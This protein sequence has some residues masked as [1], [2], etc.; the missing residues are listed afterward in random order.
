[1]IRASTLRHL[2][3]WIFLLLGASTGRVAAF[4]DG[5]PSGAEKPAVV[6]PQSVEVSLVD[7]ST[8][9]L[10]LREEKIEFQTR[11]GKLV[12]PT[13]ELQRAEFRT[14][15]SSDDARLVDTAIAKLGSKEFGEREAAS[16]ALTRLGERAFAALSRAAGDSDAEVARRAREVL[17]KIREKVPAERLVVREN[18]VIWVGESKFVGRIT[19][20]SLTVETLAFGVQPLRLSDV[21][22]LRSGP[23]ANDA[24]AG[25]LPDPGTLDSYQDRVGKTILFK[26]I[27]FGAA[28]PAAAVPPAGA[29][30]VAA[31][32]GV[33]GTDIYSADSSLA[34]AAVHAG[35]LKPGE[36]GVVKVTI[37]GPQ[38]AFVGSARN[39][40][41]SMGYGAWPGSFKVSK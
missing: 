31:V 26:V 18:D 19:G 24:L 23:S 28:A 11:Y 40:V 1:M 25:A 6:G 33:W 13:S 30:A 7:G 32:G 34:L 22:S 9:R 17:E 36:S 4:S 41:T 8:L 12:V 35:V 14:R 2:H 27:G 3:I 39:G 21:R 38:P 20:P 37:L 29:F 16:A 10:T 15:L 5:E